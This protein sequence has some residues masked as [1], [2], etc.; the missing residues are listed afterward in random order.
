MISVFHPYNDNQHNYFPWSHISMHCLKCRTDPHLISSSC[1]TSGE[2]KAANA[3]G[4]FEPCDADWLSGICLF[5]A[6]WQSN[7][8]DNYCIIHSHLASLPTPRIL[9]GVSVLYPGSGFHCFIETTCLWHLSHFIKC[10]WKWTVDSEIIGEE[11]KCEQD[12]TVASDIW[13]KYFVPFHSC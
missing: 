6:S 1:L 7:R 3:M 4:C 2:P 10:D 11:A 13:V 5:V 9:T 12:K 8:T